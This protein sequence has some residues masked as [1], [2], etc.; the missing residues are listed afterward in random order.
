[1]DKDQLIAELHEYS[2]IKKSTLVIDVRNYLYLLEPYSDHFPTIF[3][4]PEPGLYSPN[5]LYPLITNQR[6]YY[7]SGHKKPI[8]LDNNKIIPLINAEITMESNIKPLLEHTRIRRNLSADVNYNTVIYKF[9]LTVIIELLNNGD[10]DTKFSVINFVKRDALVLIY[11]D[12]FRNCLSPLLNK[13]SD[14]INIDKYLEITY[15]VTGSS[16]YIFQGPDIRI[17]DWYKNQIE[18]MDITNNM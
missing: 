6:L 13:V 2:K 10:V 3:L 9:L 17:L 14:F 18:K 5:W 4:E 1:M 12:E 7:R 16:I 8:L 11:S 15:L